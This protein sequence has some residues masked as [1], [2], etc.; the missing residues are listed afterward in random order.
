VCSHL[1]LFRGRDPHRPAQSWAGRLSG[2]ATCSGRQSDWALWSTDWTSTMAMVSGSPPGP[3]QRM[4]RLPRTQPPPRQAL[5]AATVFGSG[6]LPPPVPDR[7]RCEM[8]LNPGCSL[9]LNMGFAWPGNLLRTLLRRCCRGGLSVARQVSGISQDALSRGVQA[10]QIG[11][12]LS[13]TLRPSFWRCRPH[14]HDRA[15]ATRPSS[16]PPAVAHPQWCRWA[17]MRT[18]G[19][20]KA[21]T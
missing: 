5:P 3:V 10:G 2:W 19:S 11:A 20:R 16:H 14:A 13:W 21:I 17:S 15:R 1:V 4:R 18:S 7:S 8:R 12:H 9:S 6:T